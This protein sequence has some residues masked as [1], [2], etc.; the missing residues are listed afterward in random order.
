MYVA[1]GYLG[2]WLGD[3]PSRKPPDVLYFDWQIWLLQAL[4]SRGL[5]VVT[6]IHPRGVLNEAQLLRRYSDD[7]VD[8]YF[9]IEA[10]DVD[11]YLFDFAG[12]AFFDALAS[13]CGVVLVDM[14]VRP[15]DAKSFEDLH[16]R[17]EIV[18]CTLAEGNRF[19]ADPDALAEAVE[20]AST[21][22]SWPD[23]FFETYFSS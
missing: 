15:R 6:K 3:F 9:D 21:A 23:S 8:G 22:Q 5:H 1:G 18:E 13:N 2:E 14:G 4:R 19:R 20:C 10:D 16:Q 17:C 7:I 12:T 11:C